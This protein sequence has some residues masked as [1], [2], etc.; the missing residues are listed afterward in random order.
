[1]GSRTGS[2]VAAARTRRPAPPGMASRYE[3]GASLRSLARRYRMSVK[4]VRAHL[5][6]A[7]VQIR[8]PGRPKRTAHP[9][10]STAGS[11]ATLPTEHRPAL[12]AV[13][14]LRPRP[15]GQHEK[16]E[17]E[18]QWPSFDLDALFTPVA[19]E[20]PATATAGER[21]IGFT[22]P[23]TVHRISD[24][25]IATRYGEHTAAFTRCARIGLIDATIPDDA[26]PCAE[27]HQ[28]A[29]TQE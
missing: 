17:P 6:A 23:Q 15:S 14:L 7:G 18:P 28:G 2:A 27:C 22:T 16:P 9:A 10:A 8:P 26:Q 11:T 20:P 13:H 25:P 1:M 19:P 24:T 21:C 5:V 3:A 29:P 12:A 4:T